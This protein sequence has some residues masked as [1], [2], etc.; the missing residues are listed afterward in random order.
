MLDLEL[1]QHTRNAADLTRTFVEK[2]DHLQ[3]QL[4]M[5]HTTLQQQVWR[6]FHRCV[7]DSLVQL[8]L[9]YTG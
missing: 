5:L 9:L 6:C 3:H 8:I 7:Q 2:V 4:G 1:E